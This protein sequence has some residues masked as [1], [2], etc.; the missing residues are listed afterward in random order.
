MDL[1]LREAAC[2]VTGASRGIG[3]E[4]A[5]MLA[6]E[7]AN[8]LVTGRDRE[9]LDAVAAECRALGGEAA[10]FV[11]D[12]LAAD[13]AAATVRACRASFGTPE[14]VVCNAGQNWHR[15]LPDASAE[16]FERHW[17]LNVLAP[18]SLLQEVL[19]AM[20]GAGR[21]RV[22]NVVSIS[23]KRPSQFNVAYSVTKAGQLALSRVFADAYAQHG[24]IVNAV[25]PGPVDTALWRGAL[26]EMAQARG[27][28]LAVVREQ[29]EKA[30]PRGRF[31][32]EREVA[33][34]IVFLCSERAANVS[35]AAWTVDGGAVASLL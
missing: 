29:A 9:R 33:A 10:T 2:I 28:E 32:T 19:P 20:A 11:G 22:V 31:G 21:G 4:T 12:L 13:A 16:D 1:G 17:R 23:A 27:E 5:R 26:Q 15:A 18:F 24:V 7:G 35:G 8:V 6:Q 34:V 14:V 3:A 30:I 25:L